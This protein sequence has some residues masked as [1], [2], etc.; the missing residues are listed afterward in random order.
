MNVLTPAQIEEL[1]AIFERANRDSYKFKRSRRG[2]YSNPAIARDWKW[3]LLGA[4]AIKGES[5]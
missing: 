2:T 3:F 5:K 4:D 1:R